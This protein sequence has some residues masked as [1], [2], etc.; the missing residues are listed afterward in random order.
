MTNS[1]D[2]TITNWLL[3]VCVLIVVMVAFGGYVRLT[4]SGLSIVEW[5]PVSGVV[6]PLGEE[7]WQTEFAKY[8]QTPEYQK[9]NQH[10]ALADYKRIFYVEYIHRLIAR[11]AGL[12]VVIPLFVYVLRGQILWRNSLPY[13]LIAG[14]FGFQ[15]FLGWYM[16]S[17]GLENRPAVSH[18]R[19]TIHLLMALF[20]LYLSLWMALNRIYGA[21]SHSTNSR[22]MPAY[23]WMWLVMGVLVVQIAYGGLV[24]GLKAGHASNTW[25]LMFGYL[26]PPDLLSFVQPWWKNFIETATTVHFMH[27]WFAFAVLAGAL[28]V[29]AQTR[30]RPENATHR[31]SGWLVALSSLQI[32]L[33]ISV[34][35]F[36]V[37]LWLALLHQTTAVLLFINAVYLIHR[38]AGA[39]S[40][41]AQTTPNR[42]TERAVH[43]SL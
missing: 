36:S 35:W 7:A 40:L 39:P 37:P 20:L 17:S 32:L 3:T 38:L 28:V 10:F 29:W 6:P 19:L 18:F 11:I 5:N 43:A 8:Q 42:P 26:I 33:G 9:V 24:A 4:R 15:G 14:L 1:S 21:P 12:L 27:R 22:K 23:G 2:R 30:T 34:V 13:W 16:V 25:P 41:A 31:A